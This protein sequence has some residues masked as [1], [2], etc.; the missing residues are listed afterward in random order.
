[1]S[2]HQCL[3]NVIRF[4]NRQSCIYT[5][6]ECAHGLL[7]FSRPGAIEF[8]AIAANAPQFTLD[9]AS[10]IARRSLTA[11]IR[12]ARARQQ[13]LRGFNRAGQHWRWLRHRSTSRLW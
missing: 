11:F 12:P 6:N 8:T 1:M 13:R 4:I 5:I 2:L 9:V 7:G 3:Q 10:Q